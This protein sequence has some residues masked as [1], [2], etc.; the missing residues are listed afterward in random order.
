MYVI[1]NFSSKKDLH[2]ETGVLKLKEQ[3]V[4]CALRV[5]SMCAQS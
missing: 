3:G 2:S 4:I 5:Y 1:K